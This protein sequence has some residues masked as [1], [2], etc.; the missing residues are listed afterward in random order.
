[1]RLC[2]IVDRTKQRL[3]ITANLLQMQRLIPAAKLIW[4][5]C[6]FGLLKLWR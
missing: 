6:L 1:M 5:S 4:S 3:C 2:C